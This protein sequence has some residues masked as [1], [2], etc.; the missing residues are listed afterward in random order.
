[1]W[2]SELPQ[3]FGGYWFLCIVQWSLGCLVGTN[4]LYCSCGRT[5]LKKASLSCWKRSCSSLYLLLAINSIRLIH[6]C[7]FAALCSDLNLSW[8][9][10]FVMMQFSMN[11]LT[12]WLLP[13]WYG[14]GG[15]LGTYFI[16]SHGLVLLDCPEI[17]AIVFKAGV[18]SRERFSYYVL[19]HVTLEAD[20]SIPRNQGAAI[21]I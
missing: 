17:E 9:I 16:L 3:R 14:P 4:S 11:S 2:C 1:M 7:I 6:T 10:S 15:K 19:W 13:F 18:T 5:C 12:L 21:Q 20:G 8:E